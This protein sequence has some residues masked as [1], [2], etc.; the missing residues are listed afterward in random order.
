ML[1]VAALAACSA[2]PAERRAY[3]REQSELEL[4]RPVDLSALARSVSRSARLEE[5]YGQHD[6]AIRLHERLAKIQ[7]QRGE[8]KLAVEAL[9][10][11][12]R[13]ALAGPSGRAADCYEQAAAVL[14]AAGAHDGALWIT[15][16]RQLAF[17]Y[18]WQGDAAKASEHLR[19][20]AEAGASSNDASDVDVI[21]LVRTAPYYPP[22]SGDVGGHVVVV[23]TIT[24][25]GAVENAR[26]I[27]SE[28]PQFF[29][30][31]ALDA[32]RQWRYLPKLVGGKP[33]RREGVQVKLAFAS[34]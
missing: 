30:Q 20:L 27:E 5:S 16:Q 33:V 3:R 28:P 23:L 8:T 24:E 31:L 9:Q 12:G 18:D 32:V 21:P 10:A 15:V 17:A 34:R 19:L 14:E 25:R 2:L 4:R 13:N 7:V 6:E 29:D 1:L 26:V 22:L 11:A